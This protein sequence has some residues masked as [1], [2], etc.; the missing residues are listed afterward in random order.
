MSMPASIKDAIMQR[1]VL[2]T[3]TKSFYES[4]LWRKEKEI[5]LSRMGRSSN[6]EYEKVYYH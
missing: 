3:D 5:C 4:I 6:K 2:H 1:Q